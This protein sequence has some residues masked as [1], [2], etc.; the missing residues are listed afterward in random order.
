MELNKI[1]E[2]YHSRSKHDEQIETQ[3]IGMMINNLEAFLECIDD[4]DRELVFRNKDNSK[5][6][7]LLLIDFSI[8]KLIDKPSTLELIDQHNLFEKSPELKSI[9]LKSKFDQTIFSE[10]KTKIKSIVNNRSALALI[11]KSAQFL[12]GPETNFAKYIEIE[13]FMIMEKLSFFFEKNKVLHSEEIISDVLDFRIGTIEEY[14]IND[15]REVSVIFTENELGFN[16]INDAILK[17]TYLNEASH[18]VL[19]DSFFCVQKL[20]QNYDALAIKEELT[21]IGLLSYF[22]NKNYSIIAIDWLE[23]LTSLRIIIMKLKMKYQ[24]NQVYIN[25]YDIFPSYLRDVEKGALYVIRE[26]INLSNDLEIGITLVLGPEH[27]ASA[28]PFNEKNVAT[29]INKYSYN[30]IGPSILRAIS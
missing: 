23:S 2:Q 6:Y 22:S 19:I 20:N 25:N 4:I 16:S 28:Y 12:N 30:Y 9:L 18:N 14:L 8:S 10:I 3:L 24:I 21:D 13:H 11:T 5:L 7:K 17:K 1:I 26:L 27:H 29:E 15:D